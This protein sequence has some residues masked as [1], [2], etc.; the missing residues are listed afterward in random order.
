[1]DRTVHIQLHSTPEQAIALQETLRQFTEAFNQLCAY[2]W[3]QHEKNGVR[4]HHATYCSTKEACP[5]LVSDL[6]IQARVKA[7]EALESAFTWKARHEAS[8][9]KRVAKK[10]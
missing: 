10:P 5:G 4:L 8:Y 7:T 9:P 1:M 3:Q 2:G 6:L